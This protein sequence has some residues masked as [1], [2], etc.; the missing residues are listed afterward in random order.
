MNQPDI[1]CFSHL[2]WNFVYQRPQHLLSRFGKRQRVIFI[3]EPI[4]GG[5]QD[6]Y[7]INKEE[8]TNVWVVRPNLHHEK[9]HQQHADR[10]KEVLS[11][12][13]K[14]QDIGEFIS[15]YYTPMALQFS[16]HLQPILTVYDCMDELSAFRN[17]PENLVNL[18]QELFR[19]ADV[20]FTGGHSL[21]EHK[22]GNHSGIYPFPSSIDKEH[23][24]SSRSMSTEPEDQVNIPHPRFGFYGVIDERFNMEL[25]AGIAQRR[26]DWH[27]V[28]IGPIAKID[29]TDIPAFSNVHHLGQ[30]NYHE[31]PHYLAG[32]DVA[33]M[34]FAL[35]ESTKFISPTKTPE[36]LA[37]GKPVISTSIKDVVTPYGDQRLVYISDTA[38]EFIS[39]ADK[40]M[41][42][43][44]DQEE[45][46]KRVDVY[47]SGISWDKTWSNMALIIEKAINKNDFLNTKKNKAYV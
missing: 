29:E 11:R 44:H 38:D 42:P 45:W 34:P 4:Y 35:N 26:P 31:L 2:R 46:L 8:D 32:W 9:N 17:A 20:I 36:Y 21:Y 23:F 37:G 12:L 25:L 19:M 6:H 33:I 22:K 5:E 13:I 28:L 39:A 7:E 24:Y 41:S 27:F 10:L 43:D 47:L 1:L 15:W 16:D 40:I 3:E 18:E 30:K 14:E